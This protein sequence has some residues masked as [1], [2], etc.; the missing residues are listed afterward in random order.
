MNCTLFTATEAELYEATGDLPPYADRD[1]RAS[2][3]TLPSGQVL[4]L[5][6][7]WNEIHVLLGGHGEDHVLGFLVAGGKPVPA[8]HSG[9]ESARSFTP[10]E[11]VQLLAWVARLD[12]PR[13]RKVRR[14]LAD[15]VIANHGII[16]HHFR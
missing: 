6:P 4:E 14:F 11:T 13:V 2:I 12:E 8:M 15:A 7:A 16:V 1:S 10:A 9:S 3:T 5:G